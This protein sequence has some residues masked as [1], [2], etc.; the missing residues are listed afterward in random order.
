MNDGFMAYQLIICSTHFAGLFKSDNSSEFSE[1]VA[2]LEQSE[3]FIRPKCTTQ[4]RCQQMYNN[5]G[6][7]NFS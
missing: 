7:F 1:A 6:V 4:L 5:W 2:K 3:D